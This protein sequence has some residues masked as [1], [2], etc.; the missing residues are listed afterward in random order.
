MIEFKLFLDFKKCIQFNEN[1]GKDQKLKVLKEWKAMRGKE[2]VV[3]RNAKREN[4][5]K[6]KKRK[7]EYLRMRKIMKSKLLK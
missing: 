1:K 4:R 2:R 5:R 7:G 3:R 6:W